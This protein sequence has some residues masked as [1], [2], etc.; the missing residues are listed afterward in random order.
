MIIAATAPSTVAILAVVIAMWALVSAQVFFEYRHHQK[1]SEGKY[2]PH[3][4]VTKT[5]GSLLFVAA[6]LL[7]GVHAQVGGWF[8]LTALSLSVIGDVFLV[9][10]QRR[11]FLMGLGAFLLA[12]MAY[13]GAFIVQE[14]EVQEKELLLA[15]VSAPLVFGAGFGVA[16]WLW[17]YVDDKMKKPVVLYIATI[18]TMVALSFGVMFNGGAHFTI[19]AV[20][21]M[22]SDITVARHRFV[23]TEFK[24]RLYGLPLYYGAQILFAT[25]AAIAPFFESV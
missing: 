22:I 11:Y 7:S 1:E 6:G 19:A 9:S 15:A 3:I 13:C 16:R 25:S 10:P 12:H 23:K 8:F 14:K 20:L 21:F 18:C 2:G 17:P 5:A 4:G 24:N